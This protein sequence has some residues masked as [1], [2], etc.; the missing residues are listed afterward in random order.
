[1][2]TVDARSLPDSRANPQP[3]ASFV[4]IVQM[5]RLEARNHRGKQEKC[6]FIKFTC[7]ELW[8]LM[9]TA[10]SLMK[11]HINVHARNKV[12]DCS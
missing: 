6:K 2:G 12:E 10:K 7:L 3:C 5:L 11:L 1:M 4:V 8:I 9:G